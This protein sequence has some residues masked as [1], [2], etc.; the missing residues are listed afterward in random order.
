MSGSELETDMECEKV[1]D[2]ALQGDKLDVLYGEADSAARSRVGVHLEVCGACRE[3]LEALR[4]LRR[5]LGH[6]RLPLARPSFTPRGFVVPHWLAAA[7]LVMLA[8][9]AT[10]GV[11]G[12]LSL[13]RALA[14]QEA[15][16]ALLEQGQRASLGAIQAS[17][18]RTP[19]SAADAQAL[20]ARFEAGLDER[21]KS[22]EQQQAERLDRHF[23]SWQERAEVRRRVDMAQV[24]ASLSYLDG[25][26]G[27]QLART[28]ELMGYVLQAS[29]KR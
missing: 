27:E 2:E 1:A 14:S 28:N 8:M 12:Y 19:V 20:V 26:H 23:A 13:R 5:N 9:G 3:E 11:S 17:L 25:R 10:L 29:Q 16:A 21:L 18:A 6:W 4:G 7:A 15:R 22:S 24:A